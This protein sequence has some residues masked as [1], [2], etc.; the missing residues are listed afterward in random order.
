MDYKFFDKITWLRIGVIDQL[1]EELD[2]SVIKI[3]KKRKVYGR[4]KANILAA[5]LHE[6]ESFSTKHKSVKYLL[7]AID[8]FTKYACVK[9][10]KE[11]KVK[12]LLNAFIEVVNESNCDPN[13]VYSRKKI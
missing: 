1:A 12:T 2:K 9:P 3:F 10:L 6:M 13:K 5:D 8:V 4:F 7:R 11:K